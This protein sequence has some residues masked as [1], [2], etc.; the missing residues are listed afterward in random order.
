MA[1]I[2]RV[3]GPTVTPMSIVVPATPRAIDVLRSVSA[4]VAARAP[5]G[6]DQIDDL[7]LAVSEAASR[8]VRAVADGPAELLER[9]DATDDAVTIVLRVEGHDVDPWPPPADVDRLSW[10]VI[11]ALVDEAIERRDDDHACI[12][13]RFRVPSR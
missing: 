1:S 13:L 10:T 6:F 5:L 9:I 4:A 3:G 2:G 8:L 7:R 11:E 12:E